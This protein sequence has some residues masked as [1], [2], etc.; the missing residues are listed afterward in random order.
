MKSRAKKEIIWTAT[1][2]STSDLQKI[3]RDK[4]HKRRE[5]L[6]E[7]AVMLKQRMAT[8]V[9]SHEENPPESGHD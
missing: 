1:H 4:R 7:H 2:K 3:E 8:K 6:R 9:T 5:E